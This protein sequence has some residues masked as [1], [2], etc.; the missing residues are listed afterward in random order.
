[1][2]G[3]RR[4]GPTLRDIALE[5]GVSIATVS[6]VLTGHSA[7]S[8]ATR[9]HVL[10]AADRLGYVHMPQ[11]KRRPATA[12]SDQICVVVPVSLAHGSQLAN[13]FELALIGGIGTAL[14]ERRRDFAIVWQTPHD[15]A[16]LAAFLDATPYAGTIC[17]GQSQFHATLNRFGAAGAPLVVWGVEVPGQGYC[18]IGS[19]N[20]GGGFRATRHLLRSGRR[21]IAFIGAMPPIPA[22]R[23]PFSQIAM[24]LEGYRAALAAHDIAYD[25]AMVQTPAA[26]PFEGTEAVDNLLERGIGFDAIV[27]ASDLVALSAI[28]A[29]RRR[30]RRVPE[31]VAVIGYD[32]ID[33]AALSSPGLTT[34]RQD[35]IKAGNLLVS[36]L[37][38]IVDGHRARSEQLPTDLVI[39]ESCGN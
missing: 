17:L 2:A 22:A 3:S 31:D 29:L 18:S 12:L 36:K 35:V 26:G 14:R 39:R 15:D 27:A 5:T 10:G 32:D 21:R 19:D 30:G 16:T 13:P 23:T 1:M 33:A 28:Q 4:N 38:R 7:I 20:R 6:R 8:D 25:P 34:V 9:D 37:M 11:R 24:R